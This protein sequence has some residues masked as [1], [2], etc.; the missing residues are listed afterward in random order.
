[1]DLDVTNTFSK[2]MQCLEAELLYRL[3]K[4]PN[5]LVQ[6]YWYQKSSFHF[7]RAGNYCIL[8]FA[9]FVVKS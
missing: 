3:Q 1:M 7:F 8:A 6:M 4:N 9:Y 2:A 5:C